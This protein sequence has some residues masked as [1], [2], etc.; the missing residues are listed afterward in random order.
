VGP[1]FNGLSKLLQG[2]AV[3]LVEFIFAVA[4]VFGSTGIIMA[5]T[6][7]TYRIEQRHQEDTQKSLRV[8]EQ[9]VG[10]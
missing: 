7:F 4:A 2:V 3:N 9:H 8:I 10:E 1:N 5:W 6:S